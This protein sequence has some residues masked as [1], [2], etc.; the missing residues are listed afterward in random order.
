[1][2][3]PANAGDFSPLSSDEES[4][5]KI[6]DK[7]ETVPNKSTVSDKEEAEYAL[8]EEEDDAV[9]TLLSLSKTF[10]SENSQDSLDN[11]ELLPIIE[12]KM[13]DAAPV[14]IGLN[15]E[16]VNAEIANLRLSN[17]ENASSTSQ[18]SRCRSRIWSR[19]GPSF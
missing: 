18:S 14:R 9:S 12:K 1:M 11:S 3:T 6:S 5:N 15:T 16:E 2:V 19:G 8:T 4:V 7:T 17:T 13:V 10:P